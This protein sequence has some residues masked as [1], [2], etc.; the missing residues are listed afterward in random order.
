M[1]VLTYAKVNL[2]L[3]LRGKRPDDYHEIETILH[4]I[5]MADEMHFEATE[6]GRIALEVE[7]ADDL[8]GHPPPVAD[9][10]VLE[11]SRLL[12]ERAAPAAGV[13]IR[14]VK[15]VPVGAGLGGGSA[16]AAGTFV[17]LNDLWSLGIADDNLPNLASSIGSDV[18]YC[19][20]GGTALATGRGEEVL[21]LSAPES[22][23]FVLGISREPLL[24]REVYA[25]HN[26][27]PGDGVARSAGMRQVLEN[28]DIAGVASLFRN[29]LELAAFRLRPELRDK[30]A[31]L[32]EA[33]ALG[34]SMSGSGPT[35]Y[36]LTSDERHAR[37]VAERV[38]AAFDN[39]AVVRSH[40]RCIERLD[41]PGPATD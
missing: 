32:I 19:L 37:D 39:V 26:T 24:T 9:N 18:V 10:V 5:G 6:D 33:G 7:S 36:G 17:A 11:A 38:E 27:I 2:F 20:Y 3:H 8:A 21:S 1:K 12:R 28:R 22:M 35:I 13:R 23:W 29:D 25:A 41:P 4:G 40:P 14:L 34:A 31:A 15:R 16:N 30:K